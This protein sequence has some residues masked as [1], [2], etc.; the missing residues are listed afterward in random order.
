MSK[1]EPKF[2][3]GEIVLEKHETNHLYCFLITK[4]SRNKIYYSTEGTTEYFYYVDAYKMQEGIMKLYNKDC[5]Y[6]ES[7]IQNFQEN[8]DEKVEMLELE[9]EDLL[10]FNDALLMLQNSK[11]EINE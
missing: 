5:G 8:I 4:V 10:R 6:S 9:R 7:D 2:K 3:V 11:E 1:V